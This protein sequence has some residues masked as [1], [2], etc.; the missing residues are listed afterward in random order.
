MESGAGRR[1]GV[2]RRERGTVESVERRVGRQEEFRQMAR[3][4]KQ[5]E[6]GRW[7]SGIDSRFEIA[8]RV[9]RKVDG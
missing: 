6:G 9:E 4:R 7:E 8:S 1:D 5:S 3:E 2:A